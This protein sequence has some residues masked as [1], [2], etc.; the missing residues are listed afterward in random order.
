MEHNHRPPVLFEFSGFPCRLDNE[1]NTL[2]FMPKGFYK[3]AD[4]MLKPDERFARDPGVNPILYL[5][6]PGLEESYKKYK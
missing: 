2:D 5:P 3:L 1:L 4:A 6:V